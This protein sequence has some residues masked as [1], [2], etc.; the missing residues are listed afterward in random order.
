MVKKVNLDEFEE[1]VKS[2]TVFVDFYADWCGPCRMLAPFVEQ[3]S[4][5]ITDVKF[6]KVN[7]DECGELANQFQVM[8]IPTMVIIKNQQV[9]ARDL[10]FKPLNQL[11][12]FINNNK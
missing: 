7:V 5:Q 12:E 1:A 11:L 10:G 4:E 6:I 9:V 2:G 8:S 3:A